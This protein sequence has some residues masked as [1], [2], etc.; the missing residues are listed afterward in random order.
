MYGSLKD[1]KTN[2]IYNCNQCKL[3]IDRDINGLKVKFINYLFFK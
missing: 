2:E 3:M 1:I